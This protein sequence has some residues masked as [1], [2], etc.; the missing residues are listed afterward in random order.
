MTRPRYFPRVPFLHGT[1]RTAARV[2]DG[3]TDGEDA[4]ADP[5][6]SGGARSTRACS[7]GLGRGGP[8]KG[9]R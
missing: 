2:T 4:W 9:G 7:S 8:K 1:A 3:R 6:A 5:V